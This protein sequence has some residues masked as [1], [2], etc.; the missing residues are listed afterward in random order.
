M[1]LLIGPCQANHRWPTSWRWYLRQEGS[2]WLLCEGPS[3]SMRRV[4]SHLAPLFALTLLWPWAY[5]ERT[6]VGLWQLLHTLAQHSIS[7][8]RDHADAFGKVRL[9][10]SCWGECSLP[11]NGCRIKIE[12]ILVEILDLG[13]RL[14]YDGQIA[15]CRAM[16]CLLASH[17][18]GWCSHW[19][20]YGFHIWHRSLCLDTRFE[21]CIQVPDE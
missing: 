17:Q 3:S 19:A 11:T 5:L 9:C 1:L 10:K 20:A 8:W 21:H 6:D 13:A 4:L 18:W 12:V 2:D 7:A 15:S 16:T 14:W